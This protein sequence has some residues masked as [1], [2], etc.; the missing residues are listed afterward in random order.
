MAAAFCLLHGFCS[1]FPHRLWMYIL[2]IDGDRGTS[3]NRPDPFFAYLH[4]IVFVSFVSCSLSIAH[5]HSLSL[6]LHTYLWIG[7]LCTSRLAEPTS[8]SHLSR[9]QTASA[10]T[11]NV[12]TIVHLPTSLL[13]LLLLQHHHHR[14]TDPTLPNANER[15]TTMV[16]NPTYLAQRTRSCTHSPRPSTYLP[17]PTTLEW[18]DD[19]DVCES[20]S[21]D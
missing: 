14:P 18:R 20:E 13:L 11:T 21:E 16:I 12:T 5:T 6:S 15:D 19:D 8:T 3:E 9:T 10:P 7:G 4:V 17:Y 2:F 1:Q